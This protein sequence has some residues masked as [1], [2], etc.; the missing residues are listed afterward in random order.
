MTTAERVARN[1]V[2]NYGREAL[3]W[4]V[5]GF[6]TDA[7]LAEMGRE[8]ARFNQGQSVSRERMRQWR[9]ALGV[10]ITFYEVDADVKRVLRDTC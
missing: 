7:N 4:L 9:K 6:D 5:A 1:I 8:F 10:R 2:R 3:T